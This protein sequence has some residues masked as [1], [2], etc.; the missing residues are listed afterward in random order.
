M[1]ASRRKD[2]ENL[3]DLLAEVVVV[4]RAAKEEYGRKLKKYLENRIRESSQGI[5]DGVS[6]PEIQHKPIYAR[7]ILQETAELVQK[8]HT[9]AEQYFFAKDTSQHLNSELI[10]VA[11]SLQK[12]M[13]IEQQFREQ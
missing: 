2:T 10:Q 11:G 7:E 13:E 1:A 4:R 6:L 12:V 8:A 9:N 5:F 3:N